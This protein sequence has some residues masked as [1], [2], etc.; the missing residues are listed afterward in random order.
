MRFRENMV[1]AICDK[2][3]MVGA[4]PGGKSLPKRFIPTAHQRCWN[5]LPT[6]SINTTVIV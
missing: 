1:I 4:Y 2:D 6:L 3:E 5:I